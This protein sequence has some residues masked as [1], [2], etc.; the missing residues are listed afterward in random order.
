MVAERS[1]CE[2]WRYLQCVEGAGADVAVDDP[3]RCQ[4]QSSGAAD[5]LRACVNSGTHMLTLLSPARWNARMHDSC[6]WLNDAVRM[7]VFIAPFVSSEVERDEKE[8]CAAS[9]DFA[10]DE[11]AGI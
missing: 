7:G 5:R 2:A 1:P 3:E 8:R 9:L 11:R 4:R 10:R 6:P